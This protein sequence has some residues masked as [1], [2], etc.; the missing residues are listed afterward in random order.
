M[1][2]NKIRRKG[3]K[4]ESTFV[5]HISARLGAIGLEG[6]VSS[7]NSSLLNVFKIALNM[8]L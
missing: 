3:R 5:M 7:T 6:V 4:K 1:H 8:N 2:P